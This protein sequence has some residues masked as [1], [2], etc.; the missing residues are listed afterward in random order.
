MSMAKRHRKSFYCCVPLAEQQYLVCLQ[1]PAQP[2]LEF[3]V[4]LAVS[5]MGSMSWSGP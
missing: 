5:V 4:T 2:S 1:V 3:L